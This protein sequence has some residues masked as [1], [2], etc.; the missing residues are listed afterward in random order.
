MKRIMLLLSFLS[1]L[2]LL[3]P[4][5]VFADSAKVI[6]IG[7]AQVG[8]GGRPVVGGSPLANAHIRGLI[9][10]EF[11]K[12]GVKIEW[13]F[14]K[15]AGPA[16]NE[17]F[18]NKLLDFALQGDFPA[19][20]G[21]AG[22]L[23]TKLI[24]ATGRAGTVYFG[25]PS[26]STATTLEDLKGKKVALFK[27]TNTQ[28]LVSKIL[29]QRGL[30][31]RDFKLINMDT[32][33]TQAAIATKDV[34]G[35]WF[36]PEVFQLVDRGLVKVIYTNKGQPAIL[37]RQSHLL[38]T[39]EFEKAN[40][41]YTQR[42]VN[43]AVKVAADVSEPKNLDKTL[44]EWAKSGTPYS[45]FKRDL[46]GSEIKTRSSPLLDEF[47]VAQYRD[48]VQASLKYKFIRKDFD[49]NEWIEPKYQI[50]AIK[51]LKLDGYWVEQDVKGQNKLA[52]K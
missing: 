47:F 21:K 38:V 10:E 33:T 48:A 18:A 52:A 30:S 25:V 5:S 44:Q 2:L 24:L 13:N 22:G 7:V 16:V 29:D 43:V 19:I 37:T 51:D 4:R 49:V 12:D 45:S 50:Q 42:I 6:R 14:F 31:E 8:T 35:A 20:V 17:A 15:G 11:R 40:P 23:K 26:D 39:E 1:L 27:G 28:L 34:D 41:A 36:G 46:D 32:A 9:E 3:G